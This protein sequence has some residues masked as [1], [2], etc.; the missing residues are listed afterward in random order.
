MKA[1]ELAARPSVCPAATTAH[2]KFPC[3]HGCA[4][5][6]WSPCC[7]SRDT[8]CAAFGSQAGFSV[9]AT[10]P[11]ACPRQVPRSH[12]NTCVSVVSIHWVWVCPP[13][14][15]AGQNLNQEILALSAMF[16]VYTCPTCSPSSSGTHVVSIFYEVKQLLQ[17]RP[18]ASLWDHRR[19]LTLWG[20]QRLPET[21]R[22][23]CPLC[24]H[25]DR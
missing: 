2:R 3:P 19:L 18:W 22:S 7:C 23:G 10:H 8:G 4:G 17:L 5:V 21:F 15:A 9:F 25:S 13:W 1:D 6:T 24:S 14:W 11:V 16:T 12:R 20:R